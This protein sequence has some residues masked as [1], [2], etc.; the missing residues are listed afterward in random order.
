MSKALVVTRRIRKHS[1]RGA[2]SAEYAVTMVAA[3]GFAGI[4]I[5]LLKSSAM[6]SSL[7]RP[8]RSPHRRGRRASP[9][10]Q[11]CHVVELRPVP[12]LPSWLSFCLYC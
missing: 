9:R 3:C 12:L 4:L 8:R 2:A 6:H 10:S 1:E 5:A 11:K 7:A